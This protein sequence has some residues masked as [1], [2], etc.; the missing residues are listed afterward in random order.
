MVCF[1]CL[2]ASLYSGKT[3]YGIMIFADKRF[4][5]QDKRGKLP[6]W[7]QEHLTD[8]LSNLSTEESMQ[9][10]E[11]ISS[12]GAQL[13]IA[14]NQTLSLHSLPNAGSDR[15]HSR[16]PAKISSAFRY[17]RSSN[18]KAWS[19]KSWKNRPKAN[20]KWSR[21]AQFELMYARIKQRCSIMCRSTATFVFCIHLF[22]MF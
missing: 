8:N 5:R 21:A 1:C 10:R 18:C 12:C 19:G 13:F 9:V 3:D 6:K 20:S 16:S 17:L 15:W 4:S 2:L 11:Q 14:K 7:I 22:Y